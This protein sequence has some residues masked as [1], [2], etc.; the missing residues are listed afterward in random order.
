M[1]QDDGTTDAA[2]F[3]ELHRFLEV[4]YPLTARALERQV[5]ETHALLYRW[6][7]ADPQLEPIVLTAH[8][9]VVPAD[10]EGWDQEPFSGAQVEGEIWGRGTLD[11]KLSVL[12]L[13]EAVEFLLE[14]GEEP[15]RTIYLAFGH[16]EE[17]DGHGAAAI[18]RL[19]ERQGVRALF[20]LDEGS[21]IGDGLVPGVE[22]PVAMVGLAEKGYLSLALTART[23]GAGTAAKAGHSSMPPADTPIERLARGIQVLSEN[24]MPTDLRPPVSEMLTTL[25]P[26]MS[27]LERVAMGNLWLFKPLVARQ[28]AAS[29]EGNAMIRTTGVP[30]ILRGGHKEN[31]IP[32]SAQAVVNYRILPGGSA[33]A[34]REHVESLVGD[35]GLQVETLGAAIEPSPVSPAESDSFALLRR[36]ILQVFPHVVVAPALVVA[37]TDGR[38]YTGL[39]P[40]VYRFLP[41]QL[42]A[43]RL[44]GIHG[45]NER[46]SQAA[47]ADV[48]RF[49]IQLIRN[50]AL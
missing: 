44:A 31:S 28:L 1:T 41:V 34:V 37:A 6:P 2:A 45:T 46:I 40:N 32:Q 19:L 3:A 17:R 49:Y 18:A 11:D 15:R 48:I 7:G 33:A 22:K 9:D 5:A 24:P 29:P 27:F 43:D 20:V 4:S 38:H 39:T 10:P 50:S 8:M 23:G 13:L 35:I 14:S 25:A 26:E 36:T 30:T 21:V 42:D 12:G 47:Y 16:D